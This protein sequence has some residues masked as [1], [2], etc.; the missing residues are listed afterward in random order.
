MLL[1]HGL[2]GWAENWSYTLPA[3]ASVGLRAIACDLPGFGRSAPTPRGARYFDPS[4]PYYARFVRELLDALGLERVDLVGHSLGGAV[5]AV[6][7]MCFPE[8]VRRLA[9]AAPG[10]FG[11]ELN[12]WLRLVTLPVFALLARL[13]PTFFVKGIVRANFAD[14]T[15]APEWLVPQAERH[16]RAGGAVEF[17]RVMSQLATIRGQRRALRLAWDGRAA[18][19]AAPTLIVWGRQDAILPASDAERARARLRHAEVAI[20]EGAGH[21]LQLER[22][23]EFNRAVIDF[24]CRS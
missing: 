14:P 18:E 9:L 6:T 20:I 5:V 23:E 21:L 22:P 4:D 1:V 11:V 7:A 13:E 12:A 2:G 19:L 15:R 3:L 16:A 17:V 24:L 8:R 10:G